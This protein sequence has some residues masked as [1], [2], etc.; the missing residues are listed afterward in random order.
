V[1]GMYTSGSSE[2]GYF[3]SIKESI[4]APLPPGSSLNFQTQSFLQR[5]G[6]NNANTTTFTEVDKN[7]ISFQIF[8]EAGSTTAEIYLTITKP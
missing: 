2:S 3:F 4:G 5:N 1:E 6:A 8:A 7:E